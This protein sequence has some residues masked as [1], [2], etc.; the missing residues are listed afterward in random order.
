[1]SQVFAS[2]SVV[3]GLMPEWLRHARA[4][5][6]AG[7]NPVMV[8]VVLAQGSTPREAGARLC[9]HAEYTWGSIGG[10]HLEW[11]AIEQARVLL[12]Q[13]LPRAQ[14]RR[15]PLGSS[16][17]QC[18]GGAVTL[19]FEPLDRKDLAWLDE[20]ISLVRSGVAVRRDTRLDESGRAL[21]QIQALTQPDS[22]QSRTH[23]DAQ[24]QHWQ[25]T[26]SA[27]ALPVVVCGAGH[28]GKEIVKLLGRLPVAVHWLDVRD[29]EWPVD[30]PANVVCVQGDDQDVPDMPEEAAW[31]IMTHDHALDLAIAEAV[32]RHQAFVFLGMIGSKTKAARFRSHLSRRLSAEQADRLTCPIGIV[33]TSSKLPA[34]IAVSVVAQLLPMLDGDLPD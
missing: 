4:A 25:E 15:Y 21:T 5:I 30:L 32:L 29:T 14:W 12:A 2:E 22:V 10:G 26:F 8:T 23:W 16:L 6:L 31:L 11:V 3:H 17:G 9:V 28:I 20:A 34:V 1:M 18:C 13:S 33:N 27:K 24:S 7:Q 19:L